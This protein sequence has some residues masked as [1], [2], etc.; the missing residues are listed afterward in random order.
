MQQASELLEREEAARAAV[1]ALPLSPASCSFLAV[2][3]P[4]STLN[5]LGSAALD[6]IFGTVSSAPEWTPL[7]PH[8]HTPHCA[9]GCSLRYAAH[10]HSAACN[11][12]AARRQAVWNAAWRGDADALEV[13]LALGGS[14]EEMDGVRRGWQRLQRVRPRGSPCLTQRRAARRLLRSLLRTVTSRQHMYSY[15][16]ELR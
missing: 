16:R 8:V 3:L 7:T 9:R 1:A 15:L 11:H 13:A 2:A 14:T 4:P 12:A 6:A 5:A 10:V